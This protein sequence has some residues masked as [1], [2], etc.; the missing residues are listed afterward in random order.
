MRERGRSMLGSRPLAAVSLLGLL[1]AVATL[2]PACGDET[3]GS[4]TGGGSSSGSTGGGGGTGGGPPL[5]T[6][7]S[8]KVTNNRFLVADQMLAAIEMQV[9]GEPFAELLGRDIGG[10][11]RFS[12]QTDNYIDPETGMLTSDPLGFSLAIESYEYSKQS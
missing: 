3:T 6:G 8:S 7:L 9:S 1:G 10:Y 11:D 12:A 2:A 4:S 5:P